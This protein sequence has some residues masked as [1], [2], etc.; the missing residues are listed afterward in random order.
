MLFIMYGGYCSSK[1]QVSKL[2]RQV[3]V[4]ETYLGKLVVAATFDENESLSS[5]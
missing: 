2:V 3:R 1:Q 4:S 5:S